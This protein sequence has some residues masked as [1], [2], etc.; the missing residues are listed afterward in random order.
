MAL[1]VLVVR[2]L[3]NGVEANRLPLRDRPAEFSFGRAMAGIVIH[4]C[5]AS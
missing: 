1:P 3:R 4:D 5:T 2:W